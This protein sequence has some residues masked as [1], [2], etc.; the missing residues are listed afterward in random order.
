MS[1]QVLM[2]NKS[3]IGAGAIEQAKDSLKSENEIIP[4]ADDADIS[5]YAKSAVYGL[6][7]HGI[8]SGRSDNRFEPSATL[9]RAEAA[10]MIFGITD[11]GGDIQ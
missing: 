7:S 8:I 1:Y 6:R 5:D 9:T 11:M 4:F 3:F 2:P 10:K